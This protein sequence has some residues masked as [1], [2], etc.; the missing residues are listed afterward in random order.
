MQILEIAALD[1]CFKSTTKYR[2]T[3]ILSCHLLEIN[4]SDRKLSTGVYTSVELNT[5]TKYCNIKLC[6]VCLANTLTYC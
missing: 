5:H 6:F 4:V 1:F 2:R 3:V